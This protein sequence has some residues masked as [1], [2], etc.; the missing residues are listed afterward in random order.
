MPNSNTVPDSISFSSQNNTPIIE[1]IILTETDNQN[2]PHSAEPKKK[3]YPIVSKSS[4]FWQTKKKIFFPPH[5]HH[6]RNG[7]T[8]QEQ[9]NLRYAKNVH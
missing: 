6:V 5:P 3:R 2:H 8:G 7:G 4:L 1:F 9:W